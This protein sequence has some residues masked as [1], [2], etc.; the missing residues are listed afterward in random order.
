MVSAVFAVW[1]TDFNEILKSQK[2]LVP[3]PLVYNCNVHIDASRSVMQR[4]KYRNIKALDPDDFTAVLHAWVL[5]CLR[6]TA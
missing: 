5:G 6:I 3:R 4:Y 1:N 2:L